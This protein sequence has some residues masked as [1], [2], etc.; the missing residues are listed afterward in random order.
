MA[1]RPPIGISDHKH[2]NEK[3]AIEIVEY[4]DYQCPYCRAAHPVIKEIEKTFGDQIIF[5]FRNFPLQQSHRFAMV[6]AQAAEAAAQQNKFWEMHDSIFEHQEQLSDAFL[7]YL[8]EQ[9]ELDV[10][11]F[12]ADLE[13]AHII[14]KVEDD[15]E[16]GVRSGVNGTPSFFVNGEK[17]DGGATDL[18][19]ML[20][21]ST[22]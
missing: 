17:F 13:S 22:M 12:Q 15:F 7:F 6:A 1:L 9:I 5:V 10:D 4:G 3:A 2:G 18:F 11:Q 19:E 14:K 21:D 20:K 16:S 8:A